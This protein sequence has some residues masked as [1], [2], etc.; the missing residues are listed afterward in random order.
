MPEIKLNGEMEDD[1]NDTDYSF[2]SDVDD[3]PYEYHSEGESTSNPSEGHEDIMDIADG[4]SWEQNEA[5]PTESANYSLHEG[6]RFHAMSSHLDT[7]D[8]STVPAFQNT[9]IDTDS[10]IDSVSQND[11]DFEGMGKCSEKEHLAGPG[12]VH[13][14]GYSGCSIGAEEMKGCNVMQCLFR[15]ETDWH[16]LQPDDQDFE[17][18]SNYY[19]SGVSGHVPSRDARMPHFDVERHNHGSVCAVDDILWDVS[20][21]FGSYHTKD[22]LTMTAYRREFI[23]NAFPSNVFRNLHSRLAIPSRVHRHRRTGGLASPRIRP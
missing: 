17:R 14:H 5:M 8:P 18:S 19:L 10:D 3:E 21:T 20:E 6:M 9:E 15:K 12:C 16:F 11:D 23:A 13:R 1:M 4:D 2:E 22:L 7:A